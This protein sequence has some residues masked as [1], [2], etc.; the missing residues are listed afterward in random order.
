VN[1][2]IGTLEATTSAFPGYERRV[3]ITGSEGT[4]IFKHDRIVA[5]DLKAEF[6]GGVSEQQ[7]DTNLSASSPVVSDVTG[8]KRIIEDFLRAIGS[9]S[10]PRCDGREGRRS[11]ALVQGIYK[12]AELNE[13]INLEDRNMY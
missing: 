13:P 11:V 5:A 10:S 2:A 8:H 4:V 9:N 3:E 12:S 7:Y 6:P 1:G